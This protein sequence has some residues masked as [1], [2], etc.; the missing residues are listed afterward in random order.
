MSNINF[1]DILKITGNK[2]KVTMKLLSKIA[3]I[4]S[5]SN[6]KKKWELFLNNIKPDAGN[7]ILDAGYTSIEYIGT[8]NFL[9]KNYPYAE[10]ITAIGVESPSEFIK[11]Y[12]KIKAIQ[13]DGKTFPFLDMEF[14]I[15]WSNAVLEHVGNKQQQEN[16]IKEAVRVSKVCF[17]TTP[18]KYFP[19]EVHTYTPFHFLFPKKI[20]DKYLHLIGKAWAAGD[21]MNLLSMTE[22]KKMIENLNITDYTIIQNKFFFF[23]MDFIIIIKNNNAILSKYSDQ[24]ASIASNIENKS[25]I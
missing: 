14:D 24:I 15:C 3:G 19:I 12:P 22:I 1:S 11:R 7:K 9:E 16:F 8:E 5:R 20:F 6:R 10:N 23:T 13:Y 4:I 21:Y 17:L 2:S 25:E 18:N